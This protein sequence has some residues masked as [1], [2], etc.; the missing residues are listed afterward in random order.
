M[1]LRRLWKVM[2]NGRSWKVIV[3]LFLTLD[4]HFRREKLLV[5]MV[6]SRII[7]SV[8]VPV[9]FLWTLDFM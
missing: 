9:P 1:E 5:V 3:G 7:L 8:P 6:A 2:D 4:C